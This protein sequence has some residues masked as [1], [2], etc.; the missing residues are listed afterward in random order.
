MT[1]NN[2][3]QSNIEA[4]VMMLVLIILVIVFLGSIYLMY[5]SYW[6]EHILYESLICVQER[7]QTQAC[8]K[9]AKG[10]IQSILF[11]KEA[12]ELTIQNGG[13]LSRAKIIMKIDPPVFDP[14]TFVF[15]KELRI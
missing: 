15:K 6:T 10:K 1:K 11:F 2:R 14:Q 12:F 5:S 13:R 4:A 8:V 7:G 3:G 9:E